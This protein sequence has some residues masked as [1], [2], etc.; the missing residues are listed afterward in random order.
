M[1]C[2]KFAEEVLMLKAVH[3][4]YGELADVLSFAHAVIWVEEFPTI[5]TSV[6][7]RAHYKKT[8]GH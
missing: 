3:N 7:T 8:A 4:R 1:L 5:D 2:G 6:I